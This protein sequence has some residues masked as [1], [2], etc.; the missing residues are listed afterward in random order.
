MK[1]GSRLIAAITCVTLMV[2]ALPAAVFADSRE[3]ATVVVPPQPVENLHD[4][5]T[6]HNLIQPGYSSGGTMQYSLDGVTYWTSIPTASAGGVYTIYY[7]A[8]GDNNHSDSPVRTCTA[9]IISANSPGLVDH[10]YLH[11]LGRHVDDGALAYYSQQLSSGTPAADVAREILTSSEFTNRNLNNDQFLEVLYRALF[12]RAP[13]ADGKR[14]HMDSL[15]RGVDRLSIINV[16]LSSVEFSN[17]CAAY[18]VSNTGAVSSVT[19]V[20]SSTNIINFVGRL[21]RK[22]LGR[23]PDHAGSSFWS[24]QLANHQITGTNCAYGFFFSPEFT[25]ANYSNEEFVTR[26]YNVFFDRTP[27]SQ[28][29]AN[30]VGVLNSGASRESVF[31]GFAHSAEFTRICQDYG[32][33]RG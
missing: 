3:P 26:L 27:D 24:N 14:C 16:F 28:G 15:N 13:D 32:I 7:R 33:E 29:L 23:R 19:N 22:C 12:N 10:I 1:K 8:Q 4:D 17:N 25:N 6:Y 11:A 2:A 5:G 21:Y 18:G 20:D 31:Y 9:V 30:W